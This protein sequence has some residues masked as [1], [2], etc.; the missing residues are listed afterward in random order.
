MMNIN[1]KSW[2]KLRATDIVKFLSDIEESIFVEFKSDDEAPNKLVKEISAFANTYGG[3]ILLGVSDDKSV[4]GCTK[5]SEQRIHTVVHDSLFPVPNLDVKRFVIEGKKVYVIKIEEGSMPP[6][7]TSKGGIYHRI[8][9]G[10]TPIQDSGKLTELYNKRQDYISRVCNKIEL[11]PL[12]VDDDI[13]NNLVGYLDLGFS[14]TCSEETFFQRHYHDTDY[15]L[16]SEYLKGTVGSNNYSISLAGYSVFITAGRL[17]VQKDSAPNPALRAGV[18]NFLEI[19]CDGSVRAR[20]LLLGSNGGAEVDISYIAHFL[21]LFKNIYGM[22]IGKNFSKIYL[23]AHKFE[24]LT[25]IRQFN[26]FFASDITKNQAI[27]EE[28]RKLYFQHCRKYG[29]SII[30]E[31]NR[32]PVNGYNLIDKRW[33]NN[34]KVKYTQENLIKELFLSAYTTLGYIDSFELNAN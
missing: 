31:G 12:H 26:P 8:G 30:V 23:Y 32:F 9:S 16:I 25:V 3:Y 33:F 7:V 18:N 28:A 15:G 5:W 4:S 17:S 24:K 20:I 22:I 13:P 34:F 10:S 14:V 2:E 21:D 11:P 19:M 6:Y 29:N 1:N 27:K